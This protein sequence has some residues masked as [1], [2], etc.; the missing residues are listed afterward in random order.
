MLNSLRV[1]Q[2]RL[3][4]EFGELPSWK[5]REKKVTFPYTNNF[6]YCCYVGNTAI[7]GG[8]FTELCKWLLVTFMFWHLQLSSSVP[9]IL[10]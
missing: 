6:K 2:D 4:S 9:S 8:E 7:C 1:Q 10:F 5:H 3:D